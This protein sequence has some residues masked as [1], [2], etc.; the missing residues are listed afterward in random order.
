MTISETNDDGE[1][2]DADEHHDDE[3]TKSASCPGPDGAL[4]RCEGF[5]R[6]VEE[7]RLM[8]WKGGAKGNA[9]D[10]GAWSTWG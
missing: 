9:G 7:K 3:A 6:T 1:D 8:G 10:E 2:D 5:S 4:Q